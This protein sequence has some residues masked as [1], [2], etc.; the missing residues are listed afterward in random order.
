VEKGER[1]HNEPLKKEKED[2]VEV[3][4][5]DKQKAIDFFQ[6]ENIHEHKCLACGKLFF[7]KG[8]RI[9]FCNECTR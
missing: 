6:R 2:V 1:V 4:G 5:M 8:K 3:S 9:S 7:E